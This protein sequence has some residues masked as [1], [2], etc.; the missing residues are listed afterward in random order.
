MAKISQEWATFAEIISAIAVVLTLGFLVFEMR[1]N[2]N[3]IHEQTYQSLT[4][5][6]NDYRTQLIDSDRFS[7]DAKLSKDGWASLSFEE[8]QRIRL[9]YLNLF[10]VYESAYFAN[11]RQ[12]I[13]EREW[14][15]FEIG[16]CRN[17][18][19]MVRERIWEPEGFTSMNRI[20]TPDFANYVT[21]TCK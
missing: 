14:E 8:K 4:E 13:G 20:L 9:P 11:K 15:R 18:L 17:Y 3:A 1:A 19:R 21:K 7:A 6:L 16:I 2:T 12:V 5:Q 10:G